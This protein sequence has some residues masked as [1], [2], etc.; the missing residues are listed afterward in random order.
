M[1]LSVKSSIQ[2]IVERFFINIVIW[3]SLQT[4]I[5]GLLFGISAIF[6]LPRSITLR[7]FVGMFMGI[8]CPLL[9]IGRRHSLN[10]KAYVH[11]LN[12]LPQPRRWQIMGL[13]PALFVLTIWSFI[14]AHGHLKLFITYMCWGICCIC[15]SDFFDKRQPRLGDAWGWSAFSIVLLMS[16][17]FWGALWFGRTLFSPW[18][19]TFCFSINPV[20][21]GLKSIKDM[22]MRDP[23][24]D[25]LLYAFTQSGQ[26]EVY[27]LPWWSGA[28]LYLVISF[29]FLE[30]TTRSRLRVYSA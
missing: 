20:F 23:L 24:Q 27:S 10:R 14:I 21:S 5:L 11:I 22:T 28:V 19:A 2:K 7:L 25:S 4:V 13:F 15:I 16:A 12:H 29:I 8:L 26:V 17:P 30:L 1:I 3:E 9:V 18:L 6:W